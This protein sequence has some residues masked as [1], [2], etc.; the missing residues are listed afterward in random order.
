MNSK[1]ISIK[2]ISIFLALALIVVSIPFTV[3]AETASVRFGVISDIHY[4]AKELK[5]DYSE[6]YKEWLYNKHKEYDDADSLL[7]NALDGVLRNAAE[8]G[9]TYVLLPGDLTKDGEKK[10]HQALAEKLA[11][12]EAETGIPVFVVPGN[13]DINNTNACTFEN[14]VKEAA[15]PTSPEQFREI[16]AEFGYDEADSFDS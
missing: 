14:G 1:K 16:Y 11:A 8:N 3:S 5:G 9:E 10:S 12:F 2:A 6:E 13:H 4:F 15:E 7:T